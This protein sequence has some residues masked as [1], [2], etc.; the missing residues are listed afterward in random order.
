MKT[1][2]DDFKK[3]VA[4]LFY[5]Y[6]VRSGGGDTS[7]EAAFSLDSFEELDVGWIAAFITING[8][9]D[10][11]RKIPNFFYNSYVQQLV[12]QTRR[13]CAVFTR[14]SALQQCDEAA[15]GVGAS[16]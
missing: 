9:G 6:T 3:H 10:E 16:Y 14:Q 4:H 5:C 8:D 15:A 11:W 1:L 2:W 12:I 7:F 13:A